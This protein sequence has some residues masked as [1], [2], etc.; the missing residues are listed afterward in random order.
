MIVEEAIKTPTRCSFY[1]VYPSGLA[2]LRP[3]ET[4]FVRTAITETC[5][6][7]KLNPQQNPVQV[8][9]PAW[10]APA[11]EARPGKVRTIDGLLQGPTLDA[12][13]RLIETL[14]YD[15]GTR[16][17][18]AKT[19]PCLSLPVAPSLADAK[20]AAE[21]L[22]GLVGDF[23]FREEEDRSRWLCLLLATVLRHLIGTT[24][25]GLITGN[26]AGA[27]KTRLVKLIS[28]IAHGLGNPILMTWPEGSEMMTR[29]DEIR[30]RLA[31][32]LTEGASLVL[33]DNL[34][35]GEDFGSPEIDAFLTA[36]SFYDR[37]LGRNDGS[38]VGGPNGC[39]LLGTGNNVSPSG[40]TADRTLI[41]RLHTDDPNPRSRPEESF[42]IP[43]IERYVLEHRAKYLSAALTIWR[44]WIRA[45]APQP[46]GETWG[47]FESFVSTVV[48][49][50]RWLGRPD[51]IAN[52]FRE[53]AQSDTET[54]ALCAMLGLWEE[55][56]GVEA[57]GCTD[58]LTKISPGAASGEIEERKAHLREALQNLGRIG[59]WPP[60][61][62]RLGKVFA[63]YR[64]RVVDVEQR[65]GTMSAPSAGR[66]FQRRRQDVEVFSSAD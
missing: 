60:T 46:P 50:L 1:P 9:P 27:G 28:I 23:P 10:L 43:H 58:V 26:H 59:R 56:L 35:R 40:D 61:L 47:S 5:L 4:A 31:S 12:D 18:L 30:K 32:L 36:P 55:T 57:L 11:I 22:C 24:P 51:P 37:Q 42:A 53:M 54:Q 38:R 48:A 64:G 3:A 25:F 17:Y 21:L 45:E 7:W 63:G 41:V 34:P 20:A 2:T 13:G 66:R 14:G 19:L 39:L 49:I 15:P 6:L 16:L 65:D 29:G 8:N 33:I 52:R 44:A 62:P